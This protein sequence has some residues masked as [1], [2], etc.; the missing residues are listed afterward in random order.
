MSVPAAMRGAG[1]TQ[2]AF[3]AHFDSKEALLAAAFE[4]ALS[5]AVRMVDDA[6]AGRSGID[7]VIAIAERYLSEEHRDLP[8]I[9]C[10]LPALFGEAAATPL[11]Q[12]AELLARGFD[13]MRDRIER[14]GGG[15]LN[16]D[17]AMAVVV[18]LV[19]AQV[20][21]RAL[22]GNPA[23]SEVLSACRASIPDLLRSSPA[24]DT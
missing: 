15:V 23:S 6:A 14:A 7:A 5:E 16:S 8:G 18:S 3:Y 11:G 22:R 4:H 19:G 13:T 17:R 1:L 2:G 12:T 21:A 9:G 10:P 20:A 24:G